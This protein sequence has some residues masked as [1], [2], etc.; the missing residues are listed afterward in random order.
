MKKTSAGGRE[1]IIHFQDSH[2]PYTNINQAL[3]KNK[4]KTH[5]SRELLSDLKRQN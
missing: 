3:F 2:V 1:K 5:L 4:E